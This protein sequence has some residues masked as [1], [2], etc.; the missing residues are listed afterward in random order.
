MASPKLALFVTIGCLGFLGIA[1]CNK[2]A[3]TRESRNNFITSLRTSSHSRGGLTFI[4][5]AFNFIWF[6]GILLKLLPLELFSYAAHASNLTVM[7]S[8]GSEFSR[9]LSQFMG[10]HGI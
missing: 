10:P 1:N 8:V 9:Q 5:E 4:S 7:Q 3:L 6:L 2:T